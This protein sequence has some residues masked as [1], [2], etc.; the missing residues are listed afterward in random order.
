[1]KFIVYVVSIVESPRDLPYG[2]INLHT[3]IG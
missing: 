2:D 3:F 1:M